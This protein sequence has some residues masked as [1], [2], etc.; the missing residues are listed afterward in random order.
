VNIWMLAIYRSP[1]GKFNNFITQLD[2][3]TPNIT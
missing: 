3:N 1:V 2:I